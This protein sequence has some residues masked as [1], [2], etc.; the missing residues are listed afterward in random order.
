VP[1]TELVTIANRPDLTSVV[2]EITQL[3]GSTIIE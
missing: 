1:S 2:T 3:E